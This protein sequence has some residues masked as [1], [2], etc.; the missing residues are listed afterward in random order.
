VEQKVCLFN[1][2]HLRKI[3]QQKYNHTMIRIGLEIGEEGKIQRASNRR[4]I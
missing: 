1:L 3:K 2:T 4:Q